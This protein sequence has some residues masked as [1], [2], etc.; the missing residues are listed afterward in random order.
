MSRI[1]K[2]IQ[3]VIG[4]WR[5]HH[6]KIAPASF[7]EFFIP[8]FN[9]CFLVR[10]TIIILVCYLIFG[11]VLIPCFIKGGSMEPTYKKIGF[12]FCWRGRYLFRKPEYG[13]IIILKYTKKVLLLKRVVGLPGDTIEFRDGTLYRNGKPQKESYIRYISNWTL[14]PRKVKQGYIYVVGDNRSMPINRH[15]FGQ[16]S[17]TRIYGAPLW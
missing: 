5:G 10:I 14:P 17:K 7:S 16:I 6:D 1:K 15:K 4:C 3:Y 12:N 2:T 13:D 11:F 9:T 8:K